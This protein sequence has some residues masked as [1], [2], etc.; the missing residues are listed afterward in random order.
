[1]KLDNRGF[2]ITT[3]L[4]G[5]LILFLM[6]LT[7]MLGILSTHRVRMEKLIEED[8]GAR[9]IINGTSSVSYRWYIT[10]TCRYATSGTQTQTKP[11]YDVIKYD[12]ESKAINAC[13]SNKTS[14]CMSKCNTIG[15]GWELNSLG[16]C[17]TQS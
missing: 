7:S 6:L 8:N 12:T 11:Y 5:T 4:Y 1:M 13:N 14:K 3:V 16:A 9:D 10:C 15:S 17:M 2:A